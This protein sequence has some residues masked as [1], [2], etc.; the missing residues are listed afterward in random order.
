ML[1]TGYSEDEL[2]THNLDILMPSVIDTIHQKFV[3]EYLQKQKTNVPALQKTVFM[4]MKSGSIVK[5]NMKIYVNIT[6]EEGIVLMAILKPATNIELF[7][8]K[9]PVHD[10]FF[11]LANEDN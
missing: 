7:D 4:K 2:K 8:K 9:F 1:Q 10:V 3:N 5:M 11:L 6:V